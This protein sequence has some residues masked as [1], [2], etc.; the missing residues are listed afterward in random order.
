MN[1][2]RA[3]RELERLFKSLNLGFKFDDGHDNS[4]NERLRATNSLTIDGYDDDIM[5]IVV[6]YPSGVTSV[7][8]VFDKLANNYESLKLINTFNNGVFGLKAELR[9]DGYFEISSEGE[10]ITDDQIAQFTQA[11]FDNILQKSIE[12]YLLPITKLTV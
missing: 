3:K 6:Y 4:G 10:N 8:F 5:A 1:L 12:K 9:D 11:A 2:R 7:R